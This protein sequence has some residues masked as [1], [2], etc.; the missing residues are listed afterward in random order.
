MLVLQ[1]AFKNT[2]SLFLFIWAPLCLY[3]NNCQQNHDQENFS[4]TNTSTEVIENAMIN[5]NLMRENDCIDKSLRL[6][7]CKKHKKLSYYLY[8]EDFIESFIEIPSS[9]VSSESS[10]ISSKYLAGR[11]AIYN[12]HDEKVGTCSASFLCMQN[13]DGIYTDISN[14]LSVDNGLIISWLTPTTLINLELDSIIHSMVTE[15]IVLAS[16]KIGF[17]PFYG[18]T[19]NMI[20]SSDDKKIYFKLKEI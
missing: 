1:K 20:V 12:E 8:T 7:I 2:F 19:F 9:N 18:K 5:Q 16:T 6:K 17:N 10:T 3:S 11:A 14:Y 15:C 13:E 4:H